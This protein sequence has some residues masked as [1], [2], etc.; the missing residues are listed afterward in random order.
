MV[1]G[2][3]TGAVGTTAGSSG[4]TAVCGAAGTVAIIRTGAGERRAR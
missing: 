2:M 3:A 4:A 1:E